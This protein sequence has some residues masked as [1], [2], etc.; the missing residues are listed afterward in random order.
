MTI[1]LQFATTLLTVGAIFITWYNQIS[2]PIEKDTGEPYPF[3]QFVKTT[4]TNA[5]AYLLSGWVLMLLINEIGLTAI[6]SFIDLPQI[7]DN[8]TPLAGA[9]VSGLFGHKLINKFI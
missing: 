8:L 4:W 5:L 6:Q 9:V 1:F 3:G 2:D 7:I